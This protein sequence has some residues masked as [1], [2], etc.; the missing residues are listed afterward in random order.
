MID[1]LLSVDTNAP[2]PSSHEIARGVLIDAADSLREVAARL[3]GRLDRAVEILLAHRGKV[4]VSGLGKSGIIG[5]KIAATLSSTG[6][7]AVFL[8]ASEAFHG[9]LGIYTPGDPTILLSK[10]GTTAELLRLIPILRDFQSPMIG[11]VGNV[12]SPLAALVDVVLDAAVRREADPN[13]LAPTTSTTVAL[14]L[15]DALAIALL[16][17]RGFTPDDFARFHPGG[18]LGRNTRTTVAQIMHAAAQVACLAPDASVRQV[19]IEMTRRPLGAACVIDEAR[20]LHG[21]IT[22]GDLR[23]ALLTHDDIR[24]L[25]AADIMTHS[26]I[27]VAI[28]ATL[29]TALRLMEDRPSQIAVLPVIDSDSDQCVGLIRLHDIYQA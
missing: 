21:L 29:K 25:R 18:Q 17:A 28:G 5:H 27:T 3:D 4:V 19:V 22:D 6:T 2:A 11:I 14:A 12:A 15:G 1:P 7:P 16:R 24:D 23:R 10:S 9:D 20:R 8:H 26:P 13:D